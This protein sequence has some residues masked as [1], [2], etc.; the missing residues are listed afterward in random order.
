M[1]SI[2]VMES[3]SHLHVF[4]DVR[5]PPLPDSA[6]IG[7]TPKNLLVDRMYI[8][9]MSPE[10]FESVMAVTTHPFPKGDPVQLSLLRLVGGLQSDKFFGS[11]WG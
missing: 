10:V 1:V 8:K 5:H 11:P 4:S 2:I 6:E 3:M 7:S 9:L